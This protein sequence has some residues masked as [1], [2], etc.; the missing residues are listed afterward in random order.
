MNVHNLPAPLV[1][2]LTPERRVP[3]PGRLSVTTLLDSPLRRILSMKH[4]HAVEEEVSDNL[5]ALLG[6]AVHYV[7]EKGSPD[8]TETKLEIPFAGAI[9]VGV[10]DYHGDGHAIDWKVTS[11]WSIIFADGKTWEQQLQIYAFMLYLVGK[12]IEKLSVYMIL[13]D[14]NKREM[15][16][17]PDYPRIPFHHLL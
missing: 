1:R 9:I 13:R 3:T 17:N 14:W 2:A 6:S 8:E 5:W 16:K 15:Q 12:P 10:I 11:V 4:F 7:I